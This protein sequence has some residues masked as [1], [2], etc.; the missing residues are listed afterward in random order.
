MIYLL[1][2]DY[3]RPNRDPQDIQ[4]EA[5]EDLQS[6]KQLGHDIWQKDFQKAPNPLEGTW[7]R[8]NRFRWQLQH[9]DPELDI[10]I[11][12]TRLQRQSKRRRL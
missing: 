5:F 8:L 7:R 9:S 12:R 1:V 4:L 10:W 2:Y 11:E 3:G 6:A